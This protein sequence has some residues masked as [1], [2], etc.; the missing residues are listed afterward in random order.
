MIP[1]DVREF[2]TEACALDYCPV[3]FR[4]WAAEV[5][6]T[7]AVPVRP[8]P[9]D[10]FRWKNILADVSWSVGKRSAS[11]VRNNVYSARL[12]L[13]AIKHEHDT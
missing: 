10:D 9:L 13:R 12:Y 4:V 1:D 2:L 5:L 6:S 7:G 3:E 11:T 8:P